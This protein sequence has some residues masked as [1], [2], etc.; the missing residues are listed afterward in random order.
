MEVNKTTTTT[1]TTKP[2][3]SS[4]TQT[5]TT[6]VTTTP[7]TAGTTTTTTTTKPTTSSST[8][9]TTTVATT[10]PVTAGTMPTTTTPSTTY[11]N[12]YLQRTAGTTTTTK[13]T[14]SSST[15]TTTTVA[16]TTPVTA[17]TIPTT[18]TTTTPS[19]TYTNSYLQRTAGTTTTTT[20][21]K[22]T[23]SSSTQ[24]TTTVTTT[25]PVTAGTIPTTTTTTTPSATYTNDYPQLSGGKGQ[26]TYTT[27][28]SGDI[29]LPTSFDYERDSSGELL[30]LVLG[31]FKY[32]TMEDIEP[33][34]SC[35]DM[36]ARKLDDVKTILRDIDYTGALIIEDTDL[37]KIE[38][39]SLFEII[40]Y[41]QKR[42][43]PVQGVIKSK[44]KEQ[45]IKEIKKILTKL[46]ADRDSFK[47][48]AND[49]LY[50]YN[51]ASSKDSNKQY[52]WNQYNIKLN[53]I[54]ELNKTIGTL[55]NLIAS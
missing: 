53:D 42:F 39:D 1:T 23:T 43:L 30:P 44:T 9:T 12:S 8:Q 19:A 20:T 34:L 6:A 13:P 26:T 46:K 28:V 51:N 50:K 33:L 11:T 32:I 27:T 48:I 40:D 2:A 16:T 25:T 47:I 31:D 3:T 41:M 10:T 17:G 15:Q 45:Q 5:T 4:S 35:L 29:C 55:E 24:T 49:Y 21:T 22:P 54:A 18:T 38:M 36:H 52:Y 14:T 7:I 37:I